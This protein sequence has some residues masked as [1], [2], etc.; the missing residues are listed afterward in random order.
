MVVNWNL[1][2]SYGVWWKHSDW[3]MVFG[4]TINRYTNLKALVESLIVRIVRGHLCNQPQLLR[5]RCH[6]WRSHY[7]WSGGK[8]IFI[9]GT[10]RIR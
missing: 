4:K 6:Q 2:I 5:V 8:D 7:K 3:F 10:A 9:I 1:P